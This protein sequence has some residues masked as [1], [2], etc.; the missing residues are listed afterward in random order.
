MSEPSS[1][2]QAH[3]RMPADAAPPPQALNMDFSRRV[4]IHT[5]DLDWQP[6]PAAGVWRKPL[7]REFAEHGHATSVVRYD[8]G[9]HFKAHEHPRG[10]EIL[11]LD[12]TFSDEHGDFGAGSYFRNP[13]GSR[14]APFSVDGCTLFVKLHQFDPKDTTQLRI[15]T[16]ADEWLPGQGGLEVMALHTFESEHVTLVRWPAG[17]HFVRHRH[18]GGEE[19]FVLSGEL[20]DEFGRYPAGTWVRSPDG[21]THHPRAEVDTLIWLKVGHLP[22]DTPQR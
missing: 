14:H 17:E 10:E 12:G 11:V 15:D 20:I 7:A 6:S 16:Q 19:M 8:P 18:W 13:P 9:S 1:A 3:A 21:S 2:H 22:S 4:V 5:A